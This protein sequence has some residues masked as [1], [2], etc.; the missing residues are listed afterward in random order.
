[1]KLWRRTLNILKLCRF[2]FLQLQQNAY[3][4]T[5]FYDPQEVS[6]ENLFSDRKTDRKLIF[7]LVTT[8]KNRATFF[9]LF[10]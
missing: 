3:D 4:K 10:K 7:K 2:K 6:D 5:Y 9:G 1:M 8:I